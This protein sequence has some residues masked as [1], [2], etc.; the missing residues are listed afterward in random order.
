MQMQ[1]I[2]FTDPAE[3]SK[4]SRLVTVPCLTV[5]EASAWISD[6]E[7]SASLPVGII[8]KLVS[9]VHAYGDADPFLSVLRHNGGPFTFYSM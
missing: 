5:Q 7:V 3:L 2:T 9:D 1:L 8:Q 6:H 4:V